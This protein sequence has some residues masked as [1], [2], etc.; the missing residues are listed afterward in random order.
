MHCALHFEPH[1]PQLLQSVSFRLILNH[2]YFE[3]KPKNA[4]TGQTVLQYS[5][6]YLYVSH[7]IN[8]N[9]ENEK[10]KESQL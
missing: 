5:R 2:E 8:P 10:P 9:I 3:I 1:A 7:I 6:P 4:P